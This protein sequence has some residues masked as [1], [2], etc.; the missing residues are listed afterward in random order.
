MEAGQQA[1]HL[2]ETF[3]DRGVISFANIV[4]SSAYVSMGDLVR[5]VEHGETAYEQAPTLADRVWLQ[6]W[7]GWALCRSGDTHRGIEMLE[8]A[9]TIQREARYSSSE[10]FATHLCEGYW[11][12]GDYERAT[13]AL[14]EH[15]VIVERWGMRFQIG[16]AHRILG[17]ITLSSDLPQAS[18]HF[19]YSIATLREIHAKP[20]L[21]LAY[22]GYGRLCVQQGDITQARTYLNQAL[23]IFERLGTLGQPDKVR[24]VLA[25]LPEG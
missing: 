21:A 25:A 1:L 6:C 8:Q 19:E 23:D 7:L 11:L 13:N 15:L 4:L 17:E 10:L 24:H 2:G 12:A 3:V 14:R 20:E 9:V 5:G 16:S 22:A 18:D